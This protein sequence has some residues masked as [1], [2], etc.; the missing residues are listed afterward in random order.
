MQIYMQIHLGRQKE[1]S[2]SERSTAM[3]TI[4]PRWFLTRVVTLMAVCVLMGEIAVL[5]ASALAQQSTA[6]ATLVAIRAASHK[7]ATPKY[8]R[9]VFEFQ[10]SLPESLRIEYVPQLIADGSGKVIP[11]AGKA[12]VRLTVSPAVAHTDTGQSTAPQRV[13]YGLPIVQEVVRS[14][15]FESVDSYGIGLS[16][17]TT[18]HSITLTN[19]TRIVIDFLYT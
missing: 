2:S 13:K 7:E 17:K 4:V 3:L 1:P 19:P 12:I 10:G 8:D 6:P 15:D 18:F 11:I 16:Q 9:V 5:P 14:G